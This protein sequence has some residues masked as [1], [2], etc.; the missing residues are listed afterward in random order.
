MM[1]NVV[2]TFEFFFPK[3]MASINILPCKIVFFRL[4]SN[5]FLLENKCNKII[6]LVDYIHTR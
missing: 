3:F 6:E 2:D 1:E 5:F 4:S